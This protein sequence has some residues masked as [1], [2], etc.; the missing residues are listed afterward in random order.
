MTTGVG[1]LRGQPHFEGTLGDALRK[2][3]ELPQSD[4][5]FAH[6][7]VGTEVIDADAIDLMRDQKEL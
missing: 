2:Y 1:Y 5:T 7:H 6:I 3:E 4:R